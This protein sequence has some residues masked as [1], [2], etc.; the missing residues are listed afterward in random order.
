MVKHFV[1]GN[2]VGKRA[3]GTP[4]RSWQNTLEC[5]LMG[6]SMTLNKTDWLRSVCND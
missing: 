5:G 1:L 2:H 4:R 3:L 6:C